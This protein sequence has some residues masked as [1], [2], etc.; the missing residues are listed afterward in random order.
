MQLENEIFPNFLRFLGKLIFVND[1]HPKKEPS[2]I[3]FKLSGSNSLVNE[4]QN[5]NAYASINISE[6]ENETEFNEEQY[7]K[8]PSPI[9]N[10]LAEFMS[11][12]S[13]IST[14]LENE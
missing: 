4:E 1:V 7:L 11:T 13:F 9:I 2:F 10:K 14:Q 3:S 12:I 6:W 8:A 5:E